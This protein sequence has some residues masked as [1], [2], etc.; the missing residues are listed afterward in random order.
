MKVDALAL[1]KQAKPLSKE[2]GEAAAQAKGILDSFLKTFREAHQVL[3][4]RMPPQWQ[5][6]GVVK[7][8]A[9]TNTLAVLAT[10]LTRTHPK[11]QLIAG[12]LLHL[13]AP[14]DW[15][16]QTLQVLGI[17]KPTTKSLLSDIPE[18][19]PMSGFF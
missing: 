16:E 12:A 11:P 13:L 8:R 3:I 15:D 5:D 1:S 17:I 14:A 19:S 7:T 4:Q 10:Q 2:A 18:P 6:W 9:Y